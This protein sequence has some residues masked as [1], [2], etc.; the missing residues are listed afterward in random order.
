M[1]AERIDEI[2]LVL[3]RASMDGPIDSRQRLVGLALE[4][5]MAWRRATELRRGAEGVASSRLAELLKI[6]LMLREA[7][8]LLQSV[9]TMTADWLSRR[10]R[11]VRAWRGE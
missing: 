2:E 6:G 3:R 11:L 9:D 1:P 7:M 8:G 10:D 5:V 4:V